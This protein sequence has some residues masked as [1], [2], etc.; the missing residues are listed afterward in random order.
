MKKTNY[1]LLLLVALLTLGSCKSNKSNTAG[2]DEITIAYLPITHALP[3]ADLPKAKGVKVKLVKYGSWP[4]LLDALNTGRVD[5]A[6]VLIELAMKARA[7]GIGL[8]AYALGH[9]DGN[10][11]VTGKGITDVR[12]LKGKTLAIPHRASSHYIL[13][14]DAL[15]KGGLTTR[16]VNIVEL[17]PPEMPSALAN[18]RIAGYCVAEPFGAVSVSQGYGRVLFR[19]DDL[20]PGSICCALVFNDKAVA[21]KEKQLKALLSAYRADGKK[22]S[23]PKTALATARTLLTQPAPVLEQ[24]LKW[25]SYSNLNI[26]E[27]DYAV[28]ASKVKEYGIISNPPSYKE[29]VK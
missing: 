9:T 20:W 5:G 19:S 22:L 1:L 12:Q 16:D 28:L 26:T 6:S 29:F 23:N 27:H 11:I 21:G 25:I 4:E 13:L 3:L 7:Q 10:V 2:G 24:S 8:S 18:G 17:T 15:K 14:V